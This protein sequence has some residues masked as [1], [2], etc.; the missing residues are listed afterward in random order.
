MK[1]D[2]PAPGLPQ[3]PIQTD[4]KASSNDLPKFSSR[5]WVNSRERISSPISRCDSRVDSSKVVVLL[6]VNRSPVLRAF[7]TASK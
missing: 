5:N 1:L 4:G 2:F 6:I 3:I 7:N